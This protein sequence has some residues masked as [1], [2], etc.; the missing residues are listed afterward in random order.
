MDSVTFDG[1]I[2][3][4]GEELEQV[5]T[6]LKAEEFERDGNWLEPVEHALLQPWLDHGYFKVR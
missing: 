1:P 5:I 2:D 4:T 3:L 6:S